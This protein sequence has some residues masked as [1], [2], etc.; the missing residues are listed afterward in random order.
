M[1]YD[2]AQGYV[3]AN[4]DGYLIT[5]TALET[6]NYLAPQPV[7]VR[8]IINKADI[9]VSQLSFDGQ[10]FEYD[11]QQH[12]IYVTGELPQEIAAIEYE[13]N[14]KVNAGEYQVSA[15]FEYDWNN[16]NEV[17][18]MTALLTISKG[19][20]ISPSMTKPACTVSPC[21]SLPAMS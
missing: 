4:E 8:L 17:L 16:Y 1:I 10:S 15:L 13:N 20:F 14:G 5:I 19:R 7:Q 18:P 12:F 2:G 21:K 6:A 11:G 3:D 9:D